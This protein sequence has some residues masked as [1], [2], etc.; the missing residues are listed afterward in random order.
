MKNKSQR[1]PAPNDIRLRRILDETLTAPH[2]PEG[3]VMRS[4]ERRDAQALHALLEEVF[5]DGAD[6]PFEDWWPRILGDDEFDP[7][8]WFLVIDGKGLL[9]GAALCWSSGFVKDLAVHPDSRGRGIGEALM[10][11]VFL[12]FRGI[13]TAHVD[14]K[15]NT[16]GNAAALRLYERLGMIP[17]AWEG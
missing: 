2:W 3:F 4:F 8:L 7:D 6:G 17:V 1:P 10:R 15:T 5:D 16:V 11:H 13:G 14:L 9:V 12:T